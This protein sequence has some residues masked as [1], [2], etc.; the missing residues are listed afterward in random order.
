H[1]R[2]GDAMSAAQAALY[3][4]NAEVA[5]LESEVR[6][7]EETRTRLDNQRAERRAQLV[8]WRGQRSQLTQALHMWASR[9]GSAQQLVSE[10][11]ARMEAES[12]R[13]PQAEQQFRGAQERLNEA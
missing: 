4:S 10:T 9:S 6:H 11:R 5:R 3:A 7:A 8:Q 1:F 2:A 13:L 12:A